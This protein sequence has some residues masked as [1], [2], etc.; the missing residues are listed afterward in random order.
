M[1][2]T[3]FF[4]LPLRSHP[5]PTFEIVRRGNHVHQ[6]PL[7]KLTISAPLEAMGQ[8]NPVLLLP[9]WQEQEPAEYFY[10][11]TSP[12]STLNT[13]QSIAFHCYTQ[14]RIVPSLY[15]SDYI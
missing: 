11:P 1:P 13:G 3:H 12:D 4:R 7:S 9:K 15:P 2:R 10:D 6:P 8:Q 14:N 5:Q